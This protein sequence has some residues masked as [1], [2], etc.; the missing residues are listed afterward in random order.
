MDDGEAILAQQLDSQ[1]CGGLLRCALLLLANKNPHI[2]QPF[3]PKLPT[4][5]PSSKRTRGR[6]DCKG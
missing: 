6:E 3:N 5:S 2:V 1:D 4:A